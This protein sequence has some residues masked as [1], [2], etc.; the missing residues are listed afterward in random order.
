MTQLSFLAETSE[1]FRDSLSIT[2]A[3]KDKFI[4]IKEDKNCAIAL[5]FG[6]IIGQSLAISIARSPRTE[7][8]LPICLL[9]WTEL[10]KL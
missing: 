2:E 10:A 8:R 9:A 3:R 6:R 5:D 4:T 7:L 1:N